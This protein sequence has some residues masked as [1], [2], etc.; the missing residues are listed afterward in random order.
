MAPVLK[1]L[2][3]RFARLGSVFLAFSLLGGVATA[4]PFAQP[5][6]DPA[7]LA[8]RAEVPAMRIRPPVVKLDRGKVKAALAKRRAE[9][10]KLFRDYWKDGVYPHNTTTSGPLNVWLDAEGRLCAA[11]SIISASG[12]HDLVMSIAQTN[13]GIRL[14]DV[15]DGDLMRWMLTSGFTQ[16][17]IDAIQEPFDG[18]AYYEPVDQQ[19]LVEDQRLRQRYAQVDRMLVKNRKASLDAAVDRLIEENPGLAGSLLVDS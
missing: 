13:N 16:A 19:R 15:R 10:L 5:V 9:N 17:E 3:M 8:D 1:G 4:R 12:D 6:S 7:P 18:P 14:A 2:V 11:A